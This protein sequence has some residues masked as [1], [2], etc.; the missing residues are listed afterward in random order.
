MLAICSITRISSLRM[1]FS[2][3]V[4]CLWF[5][6]SVLILF[7]MHSNSRMSVVFSGFTISMKILPSKFCQ[8][9]HNIIDQ[10]MVKSWEILYDSTDR[11][12]DRWLS[13]GRSIITDNFE[14]IIVM[15]VAVSLFASLLSCN[16][17]VN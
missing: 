7:V 9:L 3:P 8:G 16:D 15:H 4:L 12:T 10:D 6:V 11:Y 5:L 14:I 17:S 2:Q 13:S 1:T